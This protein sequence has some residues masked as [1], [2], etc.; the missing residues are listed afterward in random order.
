MPAASFAATLVLDP[1]TLHTVGGVGA[2]DRMQWF[3]GHWAAWETGGKDYWR[4]QDIEE[5]SGDYRAHPGRAFLVSGRMAAVKED[6]ARPGFVNVASLKKSCAMN[7]QWQQYVWN[8]S[9]VDMIVSSKGEHYYPNS[10]NGPSGTRPAGF[11]PGSHAATAEFFALYYKYCLPP[12][13]QP[14][15]LMEVANEC[16]VKTGATACNTSWDEMIALHTAV[17]DAVHAAAADA[18]DSL[19]RPL[20]CGPVSAFPEYQINDFQDWRP[21]GQFATFVD[22]TIADTTSNHSIDCLSIHFYSFFHE[23]EDPFTANCVERT[24]GN[25]LATLDLQEAQTAAV[26][27]DGSTPLPLLVS[28]YGAAFTDKPLPYSPAHDFWVLRSVNA[29][30]MSF[31][32]R[33][34]RILKALPFIVNK[35]LWDKPDMADNSSHSYPFQLWRNVTGSDG[36]ASW[37]PTHLFK[38]YKMWR[39]FQGRRFAAAIDHADVQVQ[40]FAT[41]RGVLGS[42]WSVAVNNLNHTA[43]ASVALAWPPL[44]AGA[45]VLLVTTRRLVWDAAAGA[46]AIRTES[47]QQAPPAAIA[48]GPAELAIVTVRLTAAT[49]GVLA[50]TATVDLRTLHSPRL[51]APLASSA[52]A[53][54]AAPYTYSLASDEAPCRLRVGLGGPDSSTSDAALAALRVTVNGVPVAVDPSRQVGGP[55]HVTPKDGS[56]FTAIEMPVPAAAAAAA[57]VGG[58]VVEVWSGAASGVVVSTVAL[59][60]SRST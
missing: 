6:P 14:R 43:T 19:P 37:E 47:G 46:P 52:A 50:P 12:T 36:A 11:M 41:A 45:S 55:A 42:D 31:M 48:L 26:R 56:F 18:G 7:G 29:M 54:A 27:G 33:P 5:F 44:P 59:I 40:A 25:L 3:G 1:W 60:T 24:G 15:V 51:L 4:P 8:V 10:C 57:A 34:D 22:G 28:E 58:A 13:Q 21:G 32:D 49:S 23:G 53:A 39:F 38:F 35:A 2:L 20:V 16:D 17:G 9:E 30:L